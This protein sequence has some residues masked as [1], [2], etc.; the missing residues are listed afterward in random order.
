[1][2][3]ERPTS[4]L[5]VRGEATLNLPRSRLKRKRMFRLMSRKVAVP[6]YAP[7][8]VDSNDVDTIGC[9][10]RK[11]LFRDL[12]ERK[13][14][15]IEAL[16]RFTREFCEKHFDKVT[17]PS[18]EEWLDGTT[19]SEKRKNDLRRVH[20]G[21]HGGRPT[22]KECSR[23]KTFVK[24]EFY[25]FFK[26][27]RMI[28]SRCDKFK[29]WSGPMFKAIEHEVF[30]LPQ[31][32]K[33]TPVPERPGK[34]AGLVR[35][36]R[37]YY[38][39]DY[40]A[41]ESHF[42][43]D[44]LDAVECEL[45]RHCLSNY[46]DAEFLCQVIMGDNKM[47]TRSGVRAQCKGRRMSGDMCTSLGNGFTNYILGLFVATR[48]GGEFDGFF[49]GDDGIFYSTVE[50]TSEDY[51]E[52]GFTI[53]IEEV[54]DP[55]K[56]SFCGMI[57]SDNGDIVRDPF[58]FLMGFAWT[59]SFT[60]AGQKIMDELLRAKAL[61]ACFETPQCPIV[62]AFARRALKLTRHAN[63]RFVRDGYHTCPDE[64]KVE[65]FEPSVMTRELFSQVYGISAA[66][67]REIEACVEAGDMVGV[68]SLMPAHDDSQFYATRYLEV[69]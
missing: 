22:K 40:T 42:S 18:F 4:G 19:Y 3:I 23:I 27:A 36:G 54:A 5:L 66:L 49:E 28:N 62:G 48:K 21:L 68:S 14:S 41:F 58:R 59:S 65:R 20:V 15:V 12:P 17:A 11:R 30:K 52:L 60:G 64:V 7:I 2:P 51:N 47:V 33:H 37:K 61:S 24:S 10:F 35:A 39:T 46:V 1:M 6:G 50:M 32:I 9:G 13:P 43:S 29:A 31:F 56:A 26:H 44:I 8:C 16:K 53:K 55:R 45:Y 63:P 38:V 67:Q 69:T 34:I 25:K 57:F